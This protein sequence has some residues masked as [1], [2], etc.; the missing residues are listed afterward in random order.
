M[1][2]DQVGASLTCY[3]VVGVHSHML[4]AIMNWQ[5]LQ[6]AKSEPD[7]EIMEAITNAIRGIL[8]I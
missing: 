8:H 1:E 7:P 4:S 3:D 5:A 6:W 2:M